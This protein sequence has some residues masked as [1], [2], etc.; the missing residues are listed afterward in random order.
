MLPSRYSEMGLHRGRGRSIFQ[1][2]SAS[3]GT[4]P[5]IRVRLLTPILIALA[6]CVPTSDDDRNPIAACSGPS[7]QENHAEEH[8]PPG[9]ISMNIA[10]LSAE[11]T[12]DTTYVDGQLVVTNNCDTSMAMLA[13]P[14]DTRVT[15]TDAWEES[16]TS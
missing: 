15:V 5:V 10:M 7:F 1:C 11:L 6:H 4:G 12:T 14:I 3:R 2:S 9:C 8:R 16:L 13:S